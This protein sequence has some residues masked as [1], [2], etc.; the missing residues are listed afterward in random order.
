M[1]PTHPEDYLLDDFGHIL[2]AEWLAHRTAMHEEY[3]GLGTLIVSRRYT[4][5]LGH[6]AII[7]VV[8]HAMSRI[9]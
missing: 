1:M 6:R 9:Q 3:L 5:R 2:R 7:R 4:A 8:A